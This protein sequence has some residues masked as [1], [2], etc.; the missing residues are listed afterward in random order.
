MTLTMIERRFALLSRLVEHEANRARVAAER[1]RHTQ[2][3]NEL[4]SANAQH[5]KGVQPST[6]AGS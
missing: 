1:K 6:Q 5:V 3:H 2:H 4:A